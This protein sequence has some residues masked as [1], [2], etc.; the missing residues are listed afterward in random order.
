MSKWINDNWNSTVTE[1]LTLATWR[2]AGA[3]LSFKQV[4]EAFII[5]DGHVE[6]TLIYV[7]P[8]QVTVSVD[9]S[10]PPVGPFAMSNPILRGLS[11]ESFVWSSETGNF[12][13]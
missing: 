12:M 10:L 9:A 4:E 5:N 6:N 7:A 2:Y 8:K 13:F 3:S 1:V 11:L